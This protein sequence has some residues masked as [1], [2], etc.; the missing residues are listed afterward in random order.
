[1][2]DPLKHIDSAEL[3]TLM[4]IALG[5]GAA[6][7]AWFPRLQTESAPAGIVSLQ[8]AWTG[9]RARRIVASWNDQRMLR[10]AE[11]SVLLD[12]PFILLYSSALAAGGVLGARAAGA[13]GVLSTYDAATIAALLA[14]SAGTA[15]LL[16]LIENLGLWM[17]LRGPFAAWL[18]PATSL[19]SLVKWIIVVL[20]GVAALTLAVA[21]VAGMAY[22]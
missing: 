5:L 21:G 9:H 4:T 15:A 11:L 1:M 6:W 16:D 14:F 12:V 18:V 3:A 7:A 22:G 19:V 2:N 20:V 8:L 17:L 10:T 13:G